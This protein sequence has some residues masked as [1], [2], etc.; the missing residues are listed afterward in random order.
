MS[1]YLVLAAQCEELSHFSA[2]AECYS[3]AKKLLNRFELKDNSS[4]PLYQEVTRCYNQSSA[5]L[6]PNAEV[7]AAIW[8]VTPLLLNNRF[9]FVRSTWYQYRV[10]LHCCRLLLQIVFEMT[11]TA[12]ISKTIDL[13]TST[14]SH[15]IMG[16]FSSL[17]SQLQATSTPICALLQ[18]D[19]I[20]AFNIL[21]SSQS[22]TDLSAVIAQSDKKMGS[23][24]EVD[25]V[26]HQ[27]CTSTASLTPCSLM[28]CSTFLFASAA[29]HFFRHS[30]TQEAII[31]GL[32][33]L[34]TD[35]FCVLALGT[36]NLL[37]LP[38]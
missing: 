17:L 38:F 7:P 20:S 18:Q 11:V 13:A 27:L 16:K 31:S 23:W 21:L 9:S 19:F 35:Q 6:S 32:E 12:A 2:A 8:T 30:L 4:P 29:V 10:Y 22:S 1:K 15:G 24:E 34:G 5:K 25:G 3:S 14:V 36:F 28:K 37:S 26:F 33:P